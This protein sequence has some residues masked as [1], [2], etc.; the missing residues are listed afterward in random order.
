MSLEVVIKVR[1]SLLRMFAVVIIFCAGAPLAAKA[2]NLVA[3][4]SFEQPGLVDGDYTVDFGSLA[5]NAVP[6]WTFG[7]STG[8]TPGVYDGLASNSGGLNDGNIEDGTNAAFL[9]GGSMAQT[10]NLNAGNYALSFWAMGRSDT[11]AA[12][13]VTVSVGNLLSQTVTPD[14]TDEYLSSDWQNY[15]FYFDVPGS[16]SYPLVFQSTLPYNPPSDH[17]TFIDNVSIVAVAGIPPPTIISEPSARQMLYVGQTAQFTVQNIGSPPLYYQWWIE[18]NG[19]YVNVTNGGRFSGAANAT[20]IISN[21]NIGDSASYK[22]SVTNIGGTTNSM[23]AALTVLPDPPPGSPRG[24][25]TVINPSFEDSQLPGDTY[26]TGYGTLDPQTG[27]PGWQFS[28]SGGD[29]FSGIVTESDTL[30]GAP[31]YIPQCWQAAFIQGTGQFSQAVTF[32]SSGTNIIR[33]RAAGRSS[34]GAGSEAIAVSVDGNPVGTFT[35]L[36]TQW[37]LYN[38]LPFNATAGVH[39]IGFAGTVPYSVSDRTSFIDAVEI[40]TPAEAAAVIPPTS[41][42]YNIVFVGDSITYGATLA[43]PTTQ[44]SSVQCMQSLGTRFNLAVRMSNQGHSGAT[45]V[46]WLPSTSYFQEAEAAAS[47]L[48]TNQPGQL[49]FS[50]MLGVND[51]AQSGTDG[52]P[53][54]PPNFLANLQSI[55][56][57]FLTDYPAAYVFVHYPTWYSTNTHNGAVYDAP[58]L[59]RLQTYF[60]EI[61]QLISD[62][63]ITHPGQVFAGDKLAFDFFSDNYLTDLTPESGVEGTFYLHPNATG[64]VV[65]GTLWASAIVA[66][67]AVTPNDSYVAWLQNADVTPGTPHT[68][69]SNTLTNLLI[70][71]GAIYGNPSGLLATLASGTNLNISADI[72]N[73]PNLT[74]VLEDSINL[75]NWSSL[76]WTIS[77][78][79]AGVATGFTRHTVQVPASSLQHANFYRLMLH[80]SNNY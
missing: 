77:T 22:V 38:S 3:N 6:G 56:N 19:T 65:L 73:D 67:L 32:Q 74:V 21:L 12:N 60:P 37:T 33:F 36:T 41:P 20:L 23:V 25:V 44:A 57:Q 61:D 54:S 51:S 68:G 52:C 13:P 28:S 15:T 45:T 39:V 7:L 47:A 11:G 76:A 8:T 31:K 53:V 35:P 16:G 80:Y 78:N 71:N 42:V 58:G 62:C 63:A 5:T 48:E 55:V 30:L 59:A 2:Q 66:P 64:A 17:T 43:D 14:N 40:V 9:Q 50:I 69:F 29:S 49:V 75:V 70:S 72:R 26:T 46:D 27:V 1:P 79:Q 18:S 4:G 34:G 10:V 24:S